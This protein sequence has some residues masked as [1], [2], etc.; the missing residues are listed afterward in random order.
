MAD[1]VIAARL[2]ETVQ[3]I[4]ARLDER[5][6]TDSVCVD[7]VIGWHKTNLPTDKERI[8]RPASPDRLASPANSGRHYAVFHSPYSWLAS[9][10]AGTRQGKADEARER[11][12]NQLLTRDAAHDDQTWETFEQWVL[13]LQVHYGAPSSMPD[14]QVF[15]T[16]ALTFA[17]TH[18]AQ[19]PAILDAGLCP[20]PFTID[21]TVRA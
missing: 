5:E 10:L 9:A 11:P 7:V 18:Q 12:T 15:A 3:E 20:F 6:H 13:S 21:S 4:F 14:L 17:N 1:H 16:S 8:A 2:R 19:L